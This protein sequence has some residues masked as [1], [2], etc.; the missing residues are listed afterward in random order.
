[1]KK[2]RKCVSCSEY[3]LKEEHCGAA[4]ISAHPPKFNPNDPYAKYRRKEKGILHG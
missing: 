2:M 3:T 4:S 1:M